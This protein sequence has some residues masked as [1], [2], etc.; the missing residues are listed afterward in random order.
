MFA[1]QRGLAPS[2]INGISLHKVR[3]TRSVILVVVVFAIAATSCCMD[4]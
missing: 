3:I 2:S 1:P 4:R